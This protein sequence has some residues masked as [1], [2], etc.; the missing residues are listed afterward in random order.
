M[1]YTITPQYHEKKDC[2]IYVVRLTD[3]VGKDEFTS[4]S[5]LAKSHKGYYS[6]YR[7]VNGF[8]FK[9][10]EQAEEF[11]KDMVRVWDVN[12][13]PPTTS[14][15]S[16]STSDESSAPSISP[17]S[18]MELH[19]ALRAVIQTEG[20]AI[21]TEVRL[22][23]ILDDFKAYSEMPSAKYILRAIIADGFAQKLLL[24]GNWNNDAINLASRF[25][26]NTGFMP[27]SVEIL[28]MSLA[29]G[30]NWINQ[31]PNVAPANAVPEIQPKTSAPPVKRRKSWSKLNVEERE[32]W[33][34][35][36][37]E[38]K[39][40]ICGLTYDSIYIADSS[41]DND[42]AFYINYEVSGKLPKDTWVNLAYA[43]YDTSNRLR[44]KSI[45][46][47]TLG[48]SKGKTYNIV[49]SDYVSLNFKYYDIGKILIF[50]E[51]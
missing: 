38:I 33:L 42:I 10:E 16:V 40:S 29:Y 34:N 14:L 2:Y 4:L 51:D 15:S 20:E 18:R 21:I 5:E 23:N 28:F 41:Y 50:I 39:Q 32:E 44:K 22:V 12:H 1:D 43:I 19:K 25:A 36:L 27:N 6:S 49:D 3:R 48:D 11:C 31:L 7:G 37:I 30:L 24:I 47:S 46:T 13:T 8:V 9:T 35:S 26:S 45:L 17:S